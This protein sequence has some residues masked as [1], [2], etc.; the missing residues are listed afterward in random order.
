MVQKLFDEKENE[1][2]MLKKK[3]KIPSTQ[4]IQTSKLTN[5]EKE[6]EALSTELID[7]KSKWLNLEEKEKHLERDAK[8]LIVKREGPKN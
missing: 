5:F 3:F 4:L 7:F 6:K 1:F 8:I 2:Q